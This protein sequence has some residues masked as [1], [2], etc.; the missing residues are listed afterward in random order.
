[1]VFLLYV[2]ITAYGT[3]V[4]Q[5]VVEEESSRVVETLLS[6]VRP[7]QLML[8]KVLGPGLTGLIQ[9]VI[10]VGAGLAIAAATGTLTL[11]GVAAGTVLWGLF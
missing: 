2:S 6:T 9:M 1:M 7:W 4:A 10:L 3:L 8:A 11:S 5:G